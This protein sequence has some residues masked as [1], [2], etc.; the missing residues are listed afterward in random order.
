MVTN[1]DKFGRLLTE[2]VHR[3]KLK[4]NRLIQA[5]QD[6]LGYAIGKSGG[7]AIEYW[8]SGHVPAKLS[9]VE[10]L[11]REIHKKV[12]LG[13]EW[14][15]Q[16]LDS[17][18][19]PTPDQLCNE[20]YPSARENFRGGLSSSIPVKTYRSLI[21]R[22]NLM[23]EI[24]TALIDPNG[25][26]IVAID[27]MGGI[28]KSAIAIELAHLLNEDTFFDQ[29]VWV[30]AFEGDTEQSHELDRI[31]NSIA[32]QIA[33]PEIS[34]LETHEKLTRL[35]AVLSHRRVL[36]IL[37]NLDTAAEPEDRIIEF[38]KPLLGYSKALLTSR[39]RFFRDVFAIHLGGLNK[40]DGKSFL[41]QEASD[42]NIGRVSTLKPDDLEKI[43]AETDGS[44]LAMK[45]VVG[46]LGYLPLE[47]V[48]KHLRKAKPINRDIEEDEYIRFY[49]FIFM[50]SWELLSSDGRKLLLGMALFPA[51]H[52]GP[53][54]ALKGTTHLTDDV[55]TASIDEL[56]RLSLLEVGEVAGNVD[57]RYY[58]HSLTKN[59]VLSDIL[60]RM[61]EP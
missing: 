3:I 21:G 54:E 5:I 50:P 39:K 53:F 55:L 30:T 51:E 15:K 58:L 29:I 16:F 20:L 33:I 1:P 11:A 61:S 24:K 46:Q 49:R 26:W 47:I 22:W 23:S 56:W 2:A 41:H 36:I 10:L 45:L 28:G 42:R 8:R 40:K 43:V 7:S 9:D 27:G 38:L 59:F 37:D 31:L 25:Y 44:P 34:H 17:A 57:V 52:G 14:L 6:E 35:R 48:L 60:N 13:W 19:H 32:I 4:N 12:D 18:G